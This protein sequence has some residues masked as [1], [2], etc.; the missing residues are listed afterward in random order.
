MPTIQIRREDEILRRM[1]ATF[2]QRAGATD[3]NDSA[4]VKH[5]L[6][7]AARELSEIY[8]QQILQRDTFDI[9]TATGI[10]LDERAKEIK[11]SIL[12]RRG[13]RRAIGRLIFSRA[14]NDLSTLLIPAGATARTAEGILVR[15]AAEATISAAS[16]EQIT[17]HGVGR[18][19]EPVYAVAVTE[20]EDGNIAVSTA[21]ALVQK[22]AGVT[23]V[24]N[25]VSFVLGRDIES[26]DEFKER[27]R[28]FVSSLS[29]CT[30]DAIK[31]GIL[32]LTDP[33]STKA[34][35]F[36]HVFEDPVARGN[37]TVYIDDGSGT[38]EETEVISNED[39]TFGLAGPPADSAVGGE[40]YLYL[41]NIAIKK[42]ATL[43]DPTF[44]LTSSTR[45]AL[46]EDTT[47]Y[48]NP[49]DGKIYFVPALVNTET[50][51]ADYT[52][53]TGLIRYIQRVIDGDS[54]DRLNFPGLRAA[55]V[56]V[57]V[58]TPVVVVVPVHAVL[59]VEEG[60]NRADVIA[61]AQTRV[62]SYINTRGIS[63]DIIR[64]ELIETIMG[65]PGVTDLTLTSPT[66]NVTI[67]D[68][69]IARNLA[70]DVDI[71]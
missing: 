7:A 36:A 49:A 69:E 17:G 38:A 24:T 34:V 71:D 46:V 47:Y 53:Y 4:L 32:G 13:A 33:D 27:I 18:D 62:L 55:G 37:V 39:V 23:A 63:G 10:D 26:D 14:S 29:R 41:D 25:P 20:G 3:L 16:A 54:Q 64:N 42:T 50:I 68:N 58:K 12:Q 44:S 51:E 48:V 2:V 59:L 35:E 19:S 52:R 22:P 45:G 21:T 66:G 61:E 70:G 60:F 67:L 11:P 28:N 30:P 43:P 56:R 5:A 1:I 15:S 65:V 9:D 57:L 31:F 6:V 8:Y 40:E